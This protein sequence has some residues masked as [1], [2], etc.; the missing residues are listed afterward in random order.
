VKLEITDIVIGTGVVAQRGDALSIHY[1]GTLENGA[2]FDNSYDR[3]E[4]LDFTL[5]AAEL[6]RGMDEGLVGMRVGGKRRLRI[7]PYLGY[8]SQGVP[9]LIPPH[10][11]LVFEVELAGI[12]PP[13]TA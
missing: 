9:G 5:G 8:G 12:R 2:E 1:R 11:V 7:P 6:I 13:G 4:T 3:N 10:S